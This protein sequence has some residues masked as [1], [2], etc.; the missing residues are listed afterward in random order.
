LSSLS[1]A[2]AASAA[3]SAAIAAASGS[4]TKGQNHFAPLRGRPSP[5][6][7][8]PQTVDIRFV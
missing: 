2:S 5:G 7:D 1:A 8:G 4:A 6:G 3:S